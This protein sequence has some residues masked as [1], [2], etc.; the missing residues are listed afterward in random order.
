M[1]RRAPSYGTSGTLDARDI[2]LEHSIVLT[3][4]YPIVGALAFVAV[5]TRDHLREYQPRRIKSK[6]TATL[7]RSPHMQDIKREVWE[8]SSIRKIT[9]D[10]SD[11]GHMEFHMKTIARS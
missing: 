4:S 11:R 8:I 10:Q 3:S 1:S 2:L 5:A 7:T 9:V 6:A